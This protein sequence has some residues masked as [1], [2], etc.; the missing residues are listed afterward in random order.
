M[1]EPL[2]RGQSLNAG[3]CVEFR[4]KG[5]NLLTGD[6][7]ELEIYS[8]LLPQEAMNT[9]SRPFRRGI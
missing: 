3:D 5:L 4:A 1:G 8:S 6:D 9:V 7:H 2:V